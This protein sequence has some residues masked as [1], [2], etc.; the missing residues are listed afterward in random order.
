MPFSGQTDRFVWVYQPYSPSPECPVR[1][2]GDEWR[3]ATT[4][5]CH[6]EVA[7]KAEARRAKPGGFGV[8]PLGFAKDAPPCGR[9]ASLLEA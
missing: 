5:S 2:H 4:A 6:A 9:G 7:T 3:E 1:K 8:V